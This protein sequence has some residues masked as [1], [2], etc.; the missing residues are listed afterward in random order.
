MR[1][2]WLSMHSM[3]EAWSMG[4]GLGPRL[5]IPWLNLG[6]QQAQRSPWGW[7]ASEGHIWGETSHKET[8]VGLE[9][10]NL[11]YKT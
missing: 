8:I 2:A 5:A 3:S 4:S 11:R 9:T 1:L 7:G 6:P 10:A